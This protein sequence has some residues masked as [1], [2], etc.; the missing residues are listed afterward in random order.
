MTTKSLWLC[1]I[2]LFPH[3]TDV[4]LTL[5]PKWPGLVTCMTRLAL[6]WLMIFPK[7]LFLSVSVTWLT[8]LCRMCRIRLSH[9]WYKHR[10]DDNVGL[11]FS[12]SPIIIIN[13]IL[14][15]L[16][17]RRFQQ[18]G[19]RMQ[20][21]FANWSSR[22]LS[23]FYHFLLQHITCRTLY[24]THSMSHIACYI[25]THALTC[26]FEISCSSFCFVSA[27]IEPGQVIPLHIACAYNMADF[28][29][30]PVCL[31]TLYTACCTLIV[32]HSMSHIVC[33]KTW[34]WYITL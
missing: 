26:L 23:T 28:G 1:H 14:S 10:D 32:I 2:W 21:P 17:M 8:W 5:S 15:C 13:W 27:M 18:V 25:S 20:S 4:S 24:V 6:S 30:A 7:P 19:V 12:D 34:T 22:L 33:H 11:I 9:V 29:T 3:D 31:Q 16:L